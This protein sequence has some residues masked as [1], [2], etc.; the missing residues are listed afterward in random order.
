MTARSCLGSNA[1]TRPLRRVSPSTTVNG[2]FVPATTCAL[3]ITCSGAYTKPEPSRRREQVGA[4]P[5]TFT[6]DARALTTAG[7]LAT[8]GSGGGTAR[9]WVGTRQPNK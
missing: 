7:E 4:V 6:T 3:V 8:F 9:T 1:T 2:A 5:S